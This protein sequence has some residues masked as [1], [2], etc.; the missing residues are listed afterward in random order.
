MTTIRAE[1]LRKSFD[2]LKVLDDI[3][4]LIQPASVT[5]ILGPN[6]SGKSTLIKSILGLV[7]PDQGEIYIDDRSIRRRWEYRRRIGY[8][9]QIARFPENLKVHE[10]LRMVMDIRG[11]SEPADDELISAFGLNELM[12]RPLRV[13]SG[14]TRQ[15]INAALAFMFSPDILILDEPTA[16]LDP[17]S[18]TLL[19]EKIE[20]EKASG[21]T[22]IM[23]SHN[24]HE[25]DEMADHILFLLDGRT[26]FDGSLLALKK[27]TSKLKLEQAIVTLMEDSE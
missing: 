7:R 22:V 2:R 19:K 20:N 9:P 26:C 8:M 13:L 21:K 10:L 18:I 6:A 23:T 15:K 27:N 4:F 1:G 14:G 16:G 5:A 25:V 11:V 24:M 3:S 17:I 12:G